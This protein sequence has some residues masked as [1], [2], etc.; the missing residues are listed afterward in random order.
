MSPPCDR[1]WAQVWAQKPY[2]LKAD[3]F[4]LGMT[5]Y[6]LASMENFHAAHQFNLDS[7]VR[8]LSIHILALRIH[9]L[10]L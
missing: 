9:I 1:C 7:K 3:I 2:S 10:A 5:I 8:A 6:V 4:S